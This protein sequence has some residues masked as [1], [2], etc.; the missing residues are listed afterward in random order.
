MFRRKP[1]PNGTPQPPG[2]RDWLFNLLLASGSL[3][4]LS[5][6]LYRGHFPLRRH[7]RP[8]TAEHDPHFFWAYQLIFGTVSLVLLYRAIAEFNRWRKAG[9]GRS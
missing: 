2:I 4:Y 6:A 3:T 8:V 9:K 1:I 7:L 5:V